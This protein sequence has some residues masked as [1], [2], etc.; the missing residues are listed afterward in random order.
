MALHVRATGLSAL[1][2]LQLGMDCLK[3]QL[4]VNVYHHLNVTNVNRLQ[5][6]IH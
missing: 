5:K 4:G 1:I 3:G 6:E 2:L